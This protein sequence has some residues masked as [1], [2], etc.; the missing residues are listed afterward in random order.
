MNQVLEQ[1]VTCKLYVQ[2]PFLPNVYQSELFSGVRE[3]GYYGKSQTFSI[4]TKVFPHKHTSGCHN[5]SFIPYQKPH[6]KPAILQFYWSEI[7][8]EGV[9]L[10]R[11]SWVNHRELAIVQSITLLRFQ[12]WLINNVSLNLLNGTVMRL[13]LEIVVNQHIDLLFIQ[14]ILAQGSLLPFL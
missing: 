10:W 8:L 12:I 9:W 7:F 2:S 5:K 13:F 14:K 1:V 4:G 3:V 6:L 11:I